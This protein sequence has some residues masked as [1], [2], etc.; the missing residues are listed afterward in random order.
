MEIILTDHNL[1]AKALVSGS[2]DKFEL[3]GIIIGS[4]LGTKVANWME[5]VSD[6]QN[7][8]KRD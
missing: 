6:E 5:T 3:T 8:K 4:R 1:P 7:Q 2:P